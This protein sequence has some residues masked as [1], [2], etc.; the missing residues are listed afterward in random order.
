MS[1]S[2]AFINDWFSN[3]LK[4]SNLLILL[5]TFLSITAFK[6][7][8]F[9]EVFLPHNFFFFLHLT[10]L[11][12]MI[13]LKYFLLIYICTL[14]QTIKR[15]FNSVSFFNCSLPSFPLPYFAIAYTYTGAIPRAF[16]QILTSP[17]YVVLCMYIMISKYT[18]MIY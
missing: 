18:K 12:K 2:L 14:Y 17:M 13:H 16:I 15:I 8:V 5:N 4:L 3:T 6:E 7:M 9:K 1:T 10:N 11:I